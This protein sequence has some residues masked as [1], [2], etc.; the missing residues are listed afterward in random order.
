M[1]FA[2][3]SRYAGLPVLEVVV[4]DADG[5]S[6]TIR[7]AA[8]RTWS[9]PDTVTPLAQHVL[10]PGE[11][12]DLL[13]ARYAADPTAFWRICDANPVLWPQQLEQPGRT[14]LIAMPGR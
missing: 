5:T 6:R 7:Y 10:A 12:L 2:A 13:A 14:I 11:R 1:A 9:L 8:R 3:N 4:T